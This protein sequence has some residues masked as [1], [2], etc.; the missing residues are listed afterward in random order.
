MPQR[1]GNRAL[2]LALATTS[3]I[4]P[5]AT[6]VP[7][8]SLWL[9]EHGY[10]LHWAAAAM[11]LVSGIVGLEWWLL[12]SPS[13]IDAE[14]ALEAPPGSV[15][16]S[17][18]EAHA[19]QAVE[20]YASALTPEQVRGENAIRELALETIN[21]VAH[22]IHPGE[23]NPVWNFTVPEA[24]ALAERVAARLRPVVLD[25]M[26]LG[27]QLTVKQVLRLY[28]WRVAV[29]WAERAYDIW[30]IVRL[31]NPAAAITHEARERLTKK[32]YTNLRD[33]FTVRVAQGYVREVG[34]A[35][36]DLYG[37]RLRVTIDQR[38]EEPKADAS[39]PPERQSGFKWGRLAR[40]TKNLGSA[41]ASWLWRRRR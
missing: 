39:M 12:R 17:V 3:L 16:W 7:F 41:G 21:V 29:D 2:R 34:R 20:V 4:L 22:Q 25:N 6:L 5:A 27:D 28:E 23:V 11:V 18:R 15:E 24:L 38:A 14:A 36:I 8:G 40:Q 37:G 19:W 32:V 13:D 31:I 30:R 35:A 33:E 1:R 9:W 10:L 26:P